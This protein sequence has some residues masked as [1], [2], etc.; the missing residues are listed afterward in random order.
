LIFVLRMGVKNLEDLVAFQLA[1]EFKLEAYRL[2]RDSP[3]ASGDWRFRSQLSD[4]AAGVEM[5]LAEGWRRYVAGELV[6][7]LR[8]SRTSLAEAERW[9]AD[10]V[11]RGYFAP[12]AIVG[13]LST[14]GRCGAALT[15]LRKSL[16]PFTKKGRARAKP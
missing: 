16:E 4:A 14:A 1:V 6:T 2:I 9:L 3:G 5:C 11:A 10:G 8:Y 15:N 12:Q 13:A 7:Y